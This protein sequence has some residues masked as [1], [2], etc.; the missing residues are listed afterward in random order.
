[1]LEQGRGGGKGE[2]AEERCP[3]TRHAHSREWGRMW[4][5]VLA[6]P[7][8][9]TTWPQRLALSTELALPLSLSTKNYTCKAVGGWL[10]LV[11]W[12]F[13]EMVGQP[14]L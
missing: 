9:T 14:W 3:P 7:C 2:E 5:G 10:A 11:G 1:M 13:V 12:W 8:P 4:S 6:A